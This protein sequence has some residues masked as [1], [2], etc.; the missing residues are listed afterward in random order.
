MYANR[1]YQQEIAAEE[2]DDLHQ[3]QIKQKA[4]QKRKIFSVGGMRTAKSLQHCFPD[5]LTLNEAI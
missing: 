2:K 5:I 4:K 1:N 3:S